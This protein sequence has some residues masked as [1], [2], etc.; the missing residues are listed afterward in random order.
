MIVSKEKEF[1][2]IEVP[3]TAST[4]IKLLLEPYSDENDIPKHATANAAKRQLGGSFDQYTT[5]AVVRRPYDWLSSWYKFFLTFEKKGKKRRSAPSLKN[6]LFEDFFNMVCDK[7][8]RL[9]KK[10][11]NQIHYLED[12]KTG[13]LLISNIL[14]FDYLSSEIDSF[15]TLK[16]MT[17]LKGSMKHKNQSDPLLLTQDPDLIKAINL[18]FFR[19]FELYQK[20]KAQAQAQYGLLDLAS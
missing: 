3:K 2:F 15:L 13:D 16:E 5:Y 7:D 14:C 9:N 10:I 18:H 19:D 1:I 4:S 20:T 6:L 17:S 11:R 12:K 8:S